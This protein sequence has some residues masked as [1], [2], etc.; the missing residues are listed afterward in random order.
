MCCAGRGYGRTAL[1]ARV[2]RAGQEF[3]GDQRELF[4]LDTQPDREAPYERLL[5]D[6]VAGDGALSPGR[7]RSRPP[8][9]WS[10]LSSPTTTGRTPTS[11]DLG[12]EAG[13]QAHNL[14]RSLAQPIAGPKLT[15]SRPRGTPASRASCSAVRLLLLRPAPQRPLD[16]FVSVSKLSLGLSDRRS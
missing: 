7:M 11:G 14:R 4:L 15:S 6:A 12:T 10:I 16:V 1:A 3:L 8:G 5:G 2:K 13:Q 9:R